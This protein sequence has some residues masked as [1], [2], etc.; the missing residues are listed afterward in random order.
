MTSA[1]RAELTKLRSVRS[2]TWSLV[3]ILG[4]TIALGVVSSSTSHADGGSGDQDLVMMS[5][6][7]VYF[8]QIAAVAFGVLA[9]CSEYATGTIRATFAANP[10]RRQVLAAKVAIVGGL[11]AG[12][13][14]VA[15]VG[16]FYIGQAIL[17]G[18]GYHAASLAHGSTLRAVAIAAAY[19]VL[20]A[21]LS[22]GAA[23]ILRDT[24]AAISVVLGVLLVP[25]I[26]AGLLPENLANAIEKA[27][28]MAGIAAQERG[29]PIS[30][31]GGFAATVGWAA[32][33]LVVALWLVRRR[34]A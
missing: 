14:A 6:A 12:V 24:A 2:T 13:S 27:T 25:W 33:A 16:A 18:N 20:L 28:P 8:A 22:L 26:V 30:P 15:T 19:L 3:A 34:D 23:S 5:L 29:A 9:V 10:R 17:R 11:V 32:A 4:L 31:W 21:V 7:G 1:L